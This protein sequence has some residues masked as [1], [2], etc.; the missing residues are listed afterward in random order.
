[1]KPK[2]LNTLTCV[3]VQEQIE[4]MGPKEKMAY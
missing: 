4:E 1:M 2:I 3:W